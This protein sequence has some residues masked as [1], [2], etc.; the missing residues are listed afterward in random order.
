ML[1]ASVFTLLGIGQAARSSPDPAVSGSERLHEM[2]ARLDAG[3]RGL[4]I[5]RR[6]RSAGVTTP[7]QKGPDASDQYFLVVRDDQ[8]DP[9]EQLLETLIVTMANLIDERLH[10][11][12]KPERP[13][14]VLP[15][16]LA[17]RRRA[18]GRGCCPSHHHASDVGGGP[19]AGLRE[20]YREILRDPTLIQHFLIMCLAQAVFQG[21]E[22]IVV[23]VRG[24]DLACGGV[25]TALLHVAG[26]LGLLGGL[27]SSGSAPD[28]W[29]TA[30]G[31][32]SSRPA[33]AYR[34]SS[35]S[36]RPIVSQWPYRPSC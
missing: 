29:R 4:G 19:G 26:S 17:H 7:G 30:P 14:V 13:R 2:R 6:R 24:N 18:V 27:P 35:W 31:T 12:N 8:S 34:D 22:Q 16:L 20:T 15:H 23:S 10:R 5:Q 9:I 28:C 3:I 1:I 21:S 25:G 32:S 11:G 33:W 36:R